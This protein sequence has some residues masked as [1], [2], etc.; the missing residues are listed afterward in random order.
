[1][2]GCPD[3]MS[4]TSYSMPTSS[5][6]MSHTSYKMSNSKGNVVDPFEILDEYGAGLAQVE[7]LGFLQ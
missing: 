5:D 1:M 4:H 2:F 6:K 7:V 3:K